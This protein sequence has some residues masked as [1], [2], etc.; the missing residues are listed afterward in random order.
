ML[1][2]VLKHPINLRAKQLVLPVEIHRNIIPKSFI[3]YHNSVSNHD[4]DKVDLA[5]RRSLLILLYNLLSKPWDIYAR[6][7]FSRNPECPVLIVSKQLEKLLQ[8]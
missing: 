4:A 3:C 6:I 1:A 8:R 2:F 5:F 7:A